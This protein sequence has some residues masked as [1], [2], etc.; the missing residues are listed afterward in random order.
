MNNSLEGKVALV[1]GGSTGIGLGTAQVF[2]ERGAKVFITGRRQD[3]LDAAVK[4]I[5]HGVV[6]IRSDASKLEDLDAV[7]ARIRAEAGK[8]DIVF[9]NAGGG[10]MIPLGE[11]TPEHFDA[12]FDLN[13]RGVVFTVQKALPLMT[14]G[15]S[16][17]INGSTTSIKGTPSFSIYSASK[18]AVRNLARSWALDLRGTGIRVNVLSPG[19][20]LTPGLLGVAPEGKQDETVKMFTE[21]IPLGRMGTPREIGTVAAF[22][23]SDDASFV[24]G[25]ELFVDGGVAQI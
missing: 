12:T 2:A 18:A 23:A 8:L 24:N 22:L 21:L 6:A 15:G 4:E 19:P 14:R 20:T 11:L 17:V 16:I 10:T 25:V 13:V 9:A 3:A 7:F 5:G 1:T